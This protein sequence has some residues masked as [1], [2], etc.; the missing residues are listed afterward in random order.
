QNNVFELYH[1]I[2]LL[3]PGHLGN[4]KSFQAMFKTAKEHE[5]AEHFIHELV[6]QGMVRKQRKDTEIDWTSRHVQVVP[7]Q[8]SLEER[9]VYEQMIS[10]KG[11]VKQLDNAF[12]MLT[13]QKELCSSKEATALTLM[14][15]KEKCRDPEEKAQLEKTIAAVMRLTYNAKAEKVCE[16]IQQHEGKVL[17]ITEYEASQLY[18]QS[19]LMKRGITSVRFNGRFSKSKR[20]WMKQLFKE[21]AQVL[22]ATESGSEGINLQFC[23]TV[24]N[25]DVP[26]NPM[27]LEQRIG[28]VH[29]IGQTEQVHVYNLVVKETIENHILHVLYEKIGLFENVIGELDDILSKVNKKIIH[30]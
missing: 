30:E 5:E 26:W 4:Y 11:H 1:L 16:L 17:I 21:K 12:T 14:R 3:K 13:L 22:I 25:Y 28:R 29:R 23:D 7:I 15:L 24:I 6:N 8:F 19:F 18:L 10:L 2:S 9:T 20:D 27:K